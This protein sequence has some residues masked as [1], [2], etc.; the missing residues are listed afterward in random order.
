MSFICDNCKRQQ[1]KNIK[2]ERL[3]V[4]T[5]KKVYPPKPEIDDKGG[6]GTEIVKELIV[7]KYCFKKMEGSNMET[8]SHK[9]YT[10]LSMNK[11]GDCKHFENKYNGKNNKD[12]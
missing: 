1:P 4:E 3:I 2:V 10:Y 7:C 12:N 8:I 9:T 5:R 11:Y 6:T